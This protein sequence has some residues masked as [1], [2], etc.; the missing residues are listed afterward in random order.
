MVLCAFKVMKGRR[1]NCAQDDSER[2]VVLT[3]PAGSDL[4]KVPHSR[5]MVKLKLNYVN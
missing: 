5:Q 2:R 3:V 1:G 4:E